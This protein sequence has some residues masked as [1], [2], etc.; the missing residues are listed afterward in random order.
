M[1]R[2]TL[3]DVEELEGLCDD[4]VSDDVDY[5]DDTFLDGRRRVKAKHRLRSGGH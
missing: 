2:S 4:V 3:G 5:D 1:L